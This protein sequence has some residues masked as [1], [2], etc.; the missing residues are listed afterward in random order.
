[1][2]RRLEQ[3]RRRARQSMVC[4]AIR[5]GRYRGIGEVSPLS[6]S[7]RPSHG[8]T[9][10]SLFLL[11]FRVRFLYVLTPRLAA[12]SLNSRLCDLITSS[13]DTPRSK[14]RTVT[15]S[16]TAPLPRWWHAYA[17]PVTY[18]GVFMMVTVVAITAYLINKERTNAYEAAVRNGDNL[19]RIFEQ[20]LERTI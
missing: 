20:H 3:G 2:L 16:E 18:L 10:T 4:R 6:V 13:S 14:E 11:L 12:L 5:A 15:T 17:Q 7:L 19:T 9:A 1:D 8:A